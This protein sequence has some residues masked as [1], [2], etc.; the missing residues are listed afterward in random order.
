MAWST[1]VSAVS[2]SGAS[3]LSVFASD[4]SLSSENLGS[5]LRA[6]SDDGESRMQPTTK[7]C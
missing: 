2:I 6:V 7:E 3:P 4:R 1:A 5:L